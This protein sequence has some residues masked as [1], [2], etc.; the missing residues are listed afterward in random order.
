[1]QR[2]RVTDHLERGD[3]ER[4]AADLGGAG[5]HVPDDPNAKAHLRH[6]GG[7]PM[8]AL[9]T[10]DGRPYRG[11]AWLYSCDQGMIWA[12]MFLDLYA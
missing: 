3:D 12:A 8:A 11:R 4:N 1:V 5:A 9:Y 7:A 2:R 6:P 10:T